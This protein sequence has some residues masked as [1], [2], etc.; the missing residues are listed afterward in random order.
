MEYV[1][2]SRYV[3]I[4]QVWISYCLIAMSAMRGD[5]ERFGGCV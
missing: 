1:V 3:Y 5:S 2:S 4:D